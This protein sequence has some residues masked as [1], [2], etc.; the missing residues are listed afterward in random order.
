MPHTRPARVLSPV[1]SGKGS[2]GEALVE[3]ACAPRPQRALAPVWPMG[4]V[5]P[6]EDQVPT[7]S[8]EQP[9]G[10]AFHP[11]DARG[12]RVRI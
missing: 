7:R 2:P 10:L 11:R 9:F 5:A 6:F 8:S 4:R 1:T 12:R 3:E